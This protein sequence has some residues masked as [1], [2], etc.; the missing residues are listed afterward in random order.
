MTQLIWLTFGKHHPMALKPQWMANHVPISVHGD[1]VPVIGI[2]R[3]ASKSL[4]CYSMNGVL[5]QGAT[6][7]IKVLLFSFFEANKVVT[8]TEPTDTM[9]CVWRLLMWSFDHLFRGVH[10]ETPFGKSDG[11]P[12]GSAEA[13]LA[14]KPLADGM[15]GVI[16]LLKGDLDHFTK[17]YFMASYISN[18]PCPWFPANQGD[19]D[20]MKSTNFNADAE[21]RIATY[22]NE[23][24]KAS[25][26]TMHPL[27]QSVYLSCL[28]VEPD[29]LHILHLG[30]T[31][32]LLGSIL[33]LLTYKLGSNSP[34][35]NQENVWAVVTD[36][37][38]R[39]RPLCQ[40][41]SLIDTDN[42][43]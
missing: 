32:Y 10:P 40:L 33:W 29:E 18:C 26:T 12:L 17:K 24:F 3:A 34:I 20:G 16:W 39:E 23:N 31:Q 36:Y 9:L 13:E 6:V 21:W 7:D 15:C 8:K 30:T 19:G 27:F 1:G 5:A 4:D 14:G 38:R 11:W 28:N 22:N 35:V 2:G 25:L 37:Y 41:T 43:R 42:I